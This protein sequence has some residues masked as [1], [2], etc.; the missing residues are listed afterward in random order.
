MSLARQ[1]RFIAAARIDN[2]KLRNAASRLAMFGD[3]PYHNRNHIVGQL[4][5]YNFIRRQQAACR[6][7]IG[8]PT[9]LACQLPHYQNPRYLF[10]GDGLSSVRNMCLLGY[11][12]PAWQK[13]YKMRDRRDPASYLKI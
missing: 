1:R 11:A 13:S 8:L 3:D 12:G 6:S 5:R 10:Q 9:K 7:L 2:Q 4:R